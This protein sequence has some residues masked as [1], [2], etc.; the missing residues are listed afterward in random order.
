M[1]YEKSENIKLPRKKESTCQCKGHKFDP[2]SRKIPHITG[3]L[4]LCTTNREQPQLTAARES[5]CTAM[6][7]QHSQ[8]QMK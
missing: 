6:K 7:T 4:S 8:K 5:L 2:W 3:Q 1:K